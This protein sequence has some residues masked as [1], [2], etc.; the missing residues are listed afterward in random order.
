MSEH[1]AQ[2]IL[3]AVADG[4]SQLETGGALF[5][6]DDGHHLLIT[7]ASGPGPHA[8]REANYFLR[9]LTHTQQFASEIFRVAGAQWI[10]EWHTHPFG[11]AVPSQRDIRTYAAHLLDGDL[12]FNTF[13]SIIVTPVAPAKD[14]SL[15]FWLLSHDDKNIAIYPINPE[16]GVSQHGHAV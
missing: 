2:F 10:G 8:R 7:A 13:A 1:A 14:V 3:H 4:G 9:D 5:G 6:F 15:H 11:P 12:N 16:S